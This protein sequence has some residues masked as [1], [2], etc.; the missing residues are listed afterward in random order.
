MEPWYYM[1]LVI[2]WDASEYVRFIFGGTTYDLAGIPMRTGASAT[3]R[4]IRVILFNIANTAA[5]S[6]VYFDNF[7]FTQNEP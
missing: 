7:I 2:D 4:H 3:E 5:V 6:T 1:K